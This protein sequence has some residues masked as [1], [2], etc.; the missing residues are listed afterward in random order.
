[1]AKRGGKASRNTKK[2][3]APSALVHYLAPGAV[4]AGAFLLAL[5]THYYWGA[6]MM[7]SALVGG[8][9]VLL[10]GVTHRVWGTHRHTHTATAATYFTG[11][12]LGWV[13]VATIIG[14]TAPLALKAWFFG[15]GILWILW[16][17]VGTAHAAYH[18]SDIKGPKED[19]LFGGVISALTGGRSLKI[20]KKGN[21]VEADVQLPA[22]TTAGDVQAAKEQIAGV[23]KIG[24][25]QV[26]VTGKPGR[27]DVVKMAFAE[28]E[29]LRESVVWL[30][31]SAPGKSIAH[32]PLR[33]GMRADQK[34]LPLWI[35]GNDSATKP[36]QLPHT[37]V[38]GV[39]GAGKTGT[40]I[41]AIVEMRWRTDV[42]PIVAGPEGKTVQDFRHIFPALGLV[43]I[44]KA[45][46]VQFLRN[47]PDAI[48][49]RQAM[50]GELTRSDGT[51]GYSQWEPEIYTLHGFPL[52]SIDLEEASSFLDE[53][54]EDWDE[55][56]RTARSSGIALTCSL[57]TAVHT[58][59]TRKT[60]GQFTNSLCH[61]CVE[62]QDAKFSLSS[63]SREAGADP[64][65]WRNN[66]AGSLYAETVGTAPETW[67]TEARAFYLD[68][69]TVRNELTASKAAGCW[70]EI[71][72]GTL[73]YL[74]RGLS[75]T[76]GEAAKTE[77]QE[78]AKSLVTDETPQEITD[79]W[80]K[81]GVD[82]S[83][84]IPPPERGDEVRFPDPHADK[85]AASTEEFRK[86]IA[87]K[88]DELEARNVLVLN[89]ADLA[90][91]Y[92]KC[93]KGRSTLYDELNR[94]C[95]VG[96]LTKANGKPPY[97]IKARIRNGARDGAS[98]G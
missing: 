1:M 4:C 40:W 45:D 48:G 31:P 76:T 62:D 36:R 90:E 2:R 58:N 68:R 97:R 39:N 41:T 15:T 52:L 75:S 80:I 27:A 74:T 23:L 28:T 20:S 18:E 95:D 42:V 78:T 33:L 35:V 17:L 5:L 8:A 38:T 81:E 59:L 10:T 92:L 67:A 64:T 9:S 70:A 63:G 6:D 13:T 26:T 85:E 82:V 91:I 96:R 43:V 22:G 87:D 30:G 25:D 73:S 53:G 24:N 56:V 94:L 61:G 71:D 19:P 29:S 49:Y 16:T 50:F 46:V 3:D 32:S 79:P 89:A 60:R 69:E 65:K 7:M 47:L 72:E 54:D 11:A 34:P 51:V 21:R 77:P 55:A 88:I 83:M 57:Q 93:R 84:P 98:V 14:P 86:Q 44:G 66:Y 12:V 37:I